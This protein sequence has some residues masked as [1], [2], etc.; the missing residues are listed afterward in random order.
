MCDAVLFQRPNGTQIVGYIE[1]AERMGK[2][3]L[4]DIDDLLHGITDS[5]P[6][7]KHFNRK[8]IQSTIEKALKLADHL[9]VSTPPL[10]EYYSSYIS[11]LKI[12]V[13]RNGWNVEEQPPAPVQE[14]HKPARVIWRGSVTHLADLHTIKAELKTMAADDAFAFVMVGMERFMGYDLP[15]T[16]QYIA[17]QTLFSYFELM[18]KSEPDYGIFP[19]TD[20]S[21]NLCKS[22]IF[23]LEC[24]RAG[25]LPIVPMHF[26]EWNIPGLLRYSNKKDLQEIIKQIKA[27]KVDKVGLVEKAREFVFEHL[28]FFFFWIKLF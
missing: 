9:F 5:N 4:I 18:Y 23:A 10:K 12:T 27:G 11:P 19:L 15:D 26:P 24:L 17:W 28:M 13:V 22:N 8:D 14:Q 16:I 25:A 20:D 3:I 1:E 6:A 7:A 21:F 2:K